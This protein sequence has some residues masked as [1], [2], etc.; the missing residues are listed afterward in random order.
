MSFLKPAC[1][2]TFF[3]YFFR[4]LILSL[5]IVNKFKG[6]VS[7]PLRLLRILHILENYFRWLM[8][9]ISGIY[10]LPQATIKLGPISILGGAP[11]NKTVESGTTR[12]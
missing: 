7:K 8:Y 10:F 1:L 4:G 5:Y 3:L 6:D 2:H 12:G 9:T 11:E